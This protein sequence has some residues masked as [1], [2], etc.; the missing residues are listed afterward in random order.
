MSTARDTSPIRNLVCDAQSAVAVHRPRR[1]IG[2]LPALWVWLAA[3]TLCLAAAIAQ[4]N[5]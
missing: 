3:L 5:L 2:L 1:A 4:I